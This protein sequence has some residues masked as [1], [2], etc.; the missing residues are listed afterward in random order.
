MGLFLHLRY[1]VVVLILRELAVG[2]T[3]SSRLR[4]SDRSEVQRSFFVSPCPAPFSLRIYFHSFSPLCIHACIGAFVHTHP[5]AYHIPS[6][7]TM[8]LSPSSKVFHTL[9]APRSWLAVVLVMRKA[10]GQGSEGLLLQQAQQQWRPQGV[11]A[12][13]LC[14]SLSFNT[15]FGSRPVLSLSFNTSFGSRPVCITEHL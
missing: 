11:K 14:L 9:R 5:R 7:A 2:A 3:L 6:G 12:G 4:V 15:N 13:L 8:L 10:A 1:S